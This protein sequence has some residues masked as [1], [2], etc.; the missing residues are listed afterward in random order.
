MKKRYA[1]KNYPDSFSF[2]S[3]FILLFQN[4]DGIDTLLFGLY[5]HE[6]DENN[7]APNAR[8]VYFSYIDSAHY[9]RPREMRTYIYHETL[10]AYLDYV[11]HRGFSTAHIWACPPL[12][13]DDYILHCKPK[14]QKTP[15]D[16]RLRKWYY[17][18]LLECKNRGICDR[19][20]NRHDVYFANPKND[21]TVFPYMEGDCLPSMVEDIIEGLEEGMEVNDSS[22]EDSGRDPLMV[23]LEKST[24]VHRD[25]CIVAFLNLEGTT[26]KNVV[27]PEDAVEFGGKR[28]IDLESGGLAA[29]ARMEDETKE[30]AAGVNKMNQR[31]DSVA[32]ASDNK[33]EVEVEVPKGLLSLDHTRIIDDDEEELSCG[34]FDEREA[35]I[36]FCEENN[37]QFDEL[38][39]AKHT[40]KMLLSHLARNQQK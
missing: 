5:V 30:V 15:T 11:R 10:I 8:T 17:D 25:D 29:D 21:A 40:S 36:K 1:S 27:A 31:S 3:K 9:M 22:R 23:E 34:P 12:K 28:V 4:L 24:R 32:A 7:P 13:D 39:R 37:F 33:A 38:R 35:F 14:D 6:Y 26:E 18:M 16:R 2:R 19:V 20:T